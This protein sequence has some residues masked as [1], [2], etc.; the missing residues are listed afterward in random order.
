MNKRKTWRVPDFIRFRMG[1]R[2]RAVHFGAGNIGR[3]F[4]GWMLNHSGYEVCF[5]VRNVK[6][7][8]AVRKEKQY[9]VTLANEAKERSVVDHVNAIYVNNMRAVQEQMVAADLVTTAVGVSSLSDIAPAIARGIEKRLLHRVDSPPLHIIACENAVNGSSLLKKW[10]YAHLDPRLHAKADEKIAFPNAVVD[11]IVPAQPANAQDPL[12]V[13]VEPY[14]EWVIDRS[15][16][17]PD[18]PGIEGVILADSLE[19]YAERKLFTVNTGHCCAAYFGFAKGMTTIQEALK[20]QEIR[21][22]VE[23]VLR[24]TSQ[25]LA[26]KHGM[27]E[28]KQEHYVQKTLRRFENPAIKDKVLRVGRSPLRK[29]SANERLVRPAVQASKLGIAVPHLCSAM[30]AALSFEHEQDLE[31]VILQT[32]I[33]QKGVSHVVRRLMEIPENNPLHKDIIRKYEQLQ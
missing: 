8:E 21:E 13:R 19:P 10:V 14:F 22:R 26:V 6:Q 4:I 11:R 17:K 3:G 28:Q 23:Q 24:E 18:F 5:V 30:A 20:D 16:I 33:R 9:V 7:I 29:L 15:A 12:A 25:L 32:A 31:S 1:G 2:K 27:D